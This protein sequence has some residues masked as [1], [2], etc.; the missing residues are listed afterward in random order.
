MGVGVM[1]VTDEFVRARQAR[2]NRR[3][4][5]VDV[6]A[7]LLCQKPLPGLQA[8]HELARAN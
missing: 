8:P 7:I 4:T 6:D 3:G 2:E 1:N 5:P